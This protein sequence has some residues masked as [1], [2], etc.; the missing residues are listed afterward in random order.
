MTDWRLYYVTDPELAGGRDNVAATVEQ[1]VLGGTGVVQF[2]DKH[3]TD[4]EFRAGVLACQ[5]AIERAVAA[6]ASGAELFVNDRVEVAAELGTHLHI[7]QGD[8]TARAARAAIGPDRL[9]GISVSSRKEMAAVVREGL[10]DVVGLSPVWDTP[11][12]T[13]AAP[14]LGLAGVR[15][16]LALLPEG[17]RAVA[18]GGIKATNA[19]ALIEA[20]VDGIC[21]VSA[22]AAAPDPRLA[23]HDLIT[24]WRNA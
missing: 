8:A 21:V 20:G 6:G 2:R 11:T 19:S 23:A 15:E 4:E 16:L 5:R 12:K 13:D 10:A 22:I 9:L 3:A 14:A 7:G 1:A 17:V 24:L 18:I